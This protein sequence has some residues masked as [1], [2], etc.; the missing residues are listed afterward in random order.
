M[1]CIVA[2]GPPPPGTPFRRP[3]PAESRLWQNYPPHKTKLTYV[4]NI[5]R[6]S[7]PGGVE[8]LTN[9]NPGMPK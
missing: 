9:W 5:T 7:T 3:E 2:C 4:P 8:L 1:A 6:G